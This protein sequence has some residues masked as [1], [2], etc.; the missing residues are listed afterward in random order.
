MIQSGC[1]TVCHRGFSFLPSP[2][3]SRVTKN[4]TRAE[5][6]Y[7]CVFHSFVFLGSNTICKPPADT[8]RKDEVGSHL[9]GP[10]PLLVGEKGQGHELG[11][12]RNHGQHQRGGVCL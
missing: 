2:S 7:A 12:C 3:S 8:T 4:R 6:E 1:E 9:A 11:L 10:I 5:N